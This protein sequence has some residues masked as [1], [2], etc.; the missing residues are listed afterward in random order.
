MI[1]PVHGVGGGDRPR[2]GRIE[3][4]REV[5]VPASPPANVWFA[6]SV[7]APIRAGDRHRARVASCGVAERV[8][9]P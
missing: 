6:G 5:E 8:Q 1:E 9:W 7:A 4:H 2:A 3:R